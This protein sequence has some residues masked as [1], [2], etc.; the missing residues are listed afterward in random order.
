M[1]IEQTDRM[2][3]P[4]AEADRQVRAAAELYRQGNATAAEARCR[5]TLILTPHHRDAQVLLGLV[6]HF[7]ARYGEA[8][9]TFAALALQEPREAT[10][11]LN[12]GTARRGA[13]RFD[14]ALS[15]YARAAEL[16]ATSAEFYFNVGLTHL[17]RCDFEAARAV[18]AR[19]AAL[20]PADAEIR[21][22][23]AQACYECRRTEEG[24]RAL[25]GW[26]VLPDLT[27]EVAVNIGFLLMNLGEAARAEVAL[28]AAALDPAPDPY[29]TL[30]LV[31]AHERSN[32]LVEARSL[33]DAL[34]ADPRAS[35]LGD[36]LLLTEARL[37]ERES[38]HETACRL[39][40]Q[41]LRNIR[42]FH[43]R[44]FQLFRLAKSLDALQ[45][46]E[47]AFNALVEAHRSQAAH[48]A[49][50]APAVALRGIPTMSVTQ[51]RCDPS[52]VAIWDD[53]LAPS[54]AESPVF[55]VAFPRSGTT[56][57]ELTLDAHPQLKS[58][59]EQPFLQN[60]LDELRVPDVLYP[61]E[62]G[63]ISNVQ[64]ERVRA[65]YWERVSKKVHLERGERLVDKN[66]L[67]ILRL[68]VIRRLFPHARILLAVRH[69]CDV[70]LSCYMQHFRAPDFALLC[71][72]LK[73]LAVGYRRTMDFWYEELELLKPAVRE[74]RYENFVASFA[75]EIRGICDFLQLPWDERLL[76]SAAHARSKGY[77]STP[78]YA[79]VIQPVNQ[80]SVGR[81]RAYEKHFAQVL[82]QVRPYLER[83][84]YEA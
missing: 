31:K 62:L 24:L 73:S 66:P 7:E 45:R 10:H 11:W 6:L 55:I 44:H 81:W 41:A 82:P 21:Y 39:L 13:K 23:Y 17:D 53:S 64:L 35:S 54:V 2:Q 22:H 65:A 56:L 69:P 4:A 46:Y 36:D 52:D 74:V 71:A 9:E 40:E 78:S 83:W 68:P 18:L 33:F 67:N 25:A 49:M 59:D 51:F 5:E 15:A 26:E 34:A 42:D 80:R 32:R 20:A 3:D 48:L 63:R 79:Q 76:A 60:A 38:Q 12:L 14:A 28:H 29:V 50:T 43:L 8:E 30:T 72:D 61:A 75:T 1:A 27:S 57:L 58:M 70:V 37:A 16:G 84:G 19:A 47:E 77:I